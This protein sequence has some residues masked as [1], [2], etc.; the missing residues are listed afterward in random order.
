VT[1]AE[2]GFSYGPA[3]RVLMTALLAGPRDSTIR[4]DADRVSVRMGR[5]GWVFVAEIPRTSIVQANPVRGPVWGWGAHGWRDR[6]FVNGSSRGLVQLTIAPK[7]PGRCLA[8]PLRIG[9]L[10]LSVDRP[11]EFVRAVLSAAR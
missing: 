2:F 9:E 6:W 4:V 11:D 7:A 3:M 8:F 1:T 5:R 10:T